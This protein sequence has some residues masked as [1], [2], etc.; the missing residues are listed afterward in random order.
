MNRL[1]QPIDPKVAAAKRPERK[2]NLGTIVNEFEATRDRL[3]HISPAVSIFG[4]ARLREESPYYQLTIKIAQGLA[5]EGFAILSGGGPGI[6]EAAN[7]GAQGECKS[8][9]LNIKLPHEQR[10]NSYQDVSLHYQNFFSRKAGFVQYSEAFI[11][12]PGGF[13]TLDELSEVLTLI[14]TRMM[15]KM[16]II[17]VGREFWSPL[18]GW[19]KEQLLA[20][21][22]IAAEDLELFHLADSYE[23]VMS[24]FFEYFIRSDRAHLMQEG[25]D[26]RRC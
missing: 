22:L 24:H 11:C 7:R 17:L 8:V 21:G 6:M 25:S 13:G 15:P 4:S 16:P 5:K 19:F 2:W 18:V 10:P 12:M 20:E 26:A 14:Q 23:E 1:S 9:G 3:R